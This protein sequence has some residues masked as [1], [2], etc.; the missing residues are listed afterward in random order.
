MLAT[1]A[2]VVL[3]FSQANADWVRGHIRKDGTYVGPHQRTS[4]D[5]SPYNNY[6]FPGNYNPNTG[7]IA[8]GSPGTY[9]DRHYNG[10]PSSGGFYNNDLFNPQ[11]R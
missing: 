10:G 5:H 7:R 8:P 1:A 11:R 2:F 6:N 9:L 3:G 4:P